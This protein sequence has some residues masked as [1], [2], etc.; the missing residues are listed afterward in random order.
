MPAF[1]YA[2][3]GKGV[4]SKSRI[5]KWLIDAG[6][7]LDEEDNHGRNSFDYLFRSLSLAS[8]SLDE[9]LALSLVM[10]RGG[11][12]PTE[13]SDILPGEFPNYLQ[14]LCSVK[15]KSDEGQ[16]KIILLRG[17]DVLIG[18]RTILV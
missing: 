6:V 12:Y 3:Y 1:I 8:F 18:S 4:K 15:E 11:G 7:P 2:D 9:G 16:I 14:L 10:V 17:N 5:L 13:R